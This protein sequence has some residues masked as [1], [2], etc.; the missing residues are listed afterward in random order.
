M[1]HTCHAIGCNTNVPPEMFMCKPHWFSLPQRLRNRIW[2]TYRP[3]Q[4]DD[5]Q[6]TAEYRDAAKAALLHV[7]ATEKRIVDP[8]C[9]ELALYDMLAP[10]LR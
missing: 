7:A 8:Q 6:I 3:G 5:W 2:A 4:C 1:S 10:A 9:A